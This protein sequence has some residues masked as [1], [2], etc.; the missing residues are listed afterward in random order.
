VAVSVEIGDVLG[1][2]AIDERAAHRAEPMDR[3]L[4][5]RRLCA[6]RSPW[7]C[8]A[9]SFPDADPGRSPRRN[10]GSRGTIAW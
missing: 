10:E 8:S 9:A 6:R 1:I 7:I 2:R 4:I 5:P 3:L